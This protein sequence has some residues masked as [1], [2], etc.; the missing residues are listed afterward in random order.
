MHNNRAVSAHLCELSPRTNVIC[1]EAAKRRRRRP[2]RRRLEERFHGQARSFFTTIQFNMVMEGAYGARMQPR[3]LNPHHYPSNPARARRCINYLANQGGTFGPPYPLS[4]P[5]TVSFTSLPP[6]V[7][8]PLSSFFPSISPLLP[9]LSRWFRTLDFYVE[10][11][12]A[13]IHQ[14]RAIFAIIMEG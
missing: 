12:I 7:L 10:A 5:Q 13:P 11:G 1:I 8:P 4:Y 3:C 14:A 6:C 2:K 9:L